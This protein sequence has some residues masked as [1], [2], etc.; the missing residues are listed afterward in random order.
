M[1]ST[2]AHHLHGQL[3]LDRCPEEIASIIRENRELFDIGVH[4]P[5]ILFYYN[6]IHSNRVNRFGHYLHHHPAFLFFGPASAAERGKRAPV[7]ESESRRR[8]AYLAGFVCHFVLDSACHPYVQRKIEVD[9]I[10]HGVIEG[11]FER[12]LI[13]LSG[14][15]PVRTRLTDQIIPS[16]ENAETIRTFL[17]EFSSRDIQKCLRDMKFWH[18]VIYARTPVKRGLL[19]AGM[20]IIRMYPQ[21]NGRVM[22][23]APNPDCAD[24]SL[25]LLKYMNRSLDPAVGLIEEYFAFLRG[26][27][28]LPAA[29]SA[30]F[31]YGRAYRKIPVYSLK[32]EREY[33]V[34]GASGIS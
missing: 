28:P 14:G 33:A 7:D 10:P 2:F 27:R 21:L 29:F 30:T 19:Y 1:P 9:G 25:R 3:V 16:E 18:D 32:K 26:E 24:S 11:D 12:F 31:S 5:D 17:P 22:R 6:A 23:P 20:E 4:G 8:L 15:D 13:R 34:P